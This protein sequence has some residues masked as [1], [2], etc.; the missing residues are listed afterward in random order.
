MR[1]T[2][3]EHGPCDGGEAAVRDVLPESLSEAHADWIRR[4]LD[5][6][7][8]KYGAVLRIGWARAGE[9]LA[10]ELADAI[11]Y[12]VALGRLDLADRLAVMLGEVG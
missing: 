12:S 2:T 4:R 7:E 6:G 10:E 8:A 1:A 9:A 11:A 3:S 5:A